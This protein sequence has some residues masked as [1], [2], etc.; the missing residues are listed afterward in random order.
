M[1]MWEEGRENSVKEWEEG[2][3]KQCKRVIKFQG[4]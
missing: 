3:E 1:V 2:G 4:K